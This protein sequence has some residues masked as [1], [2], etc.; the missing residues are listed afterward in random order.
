MLILLVCT[1]LIAACGRQASTDDSGIQVTLLPSPAGQAGEFVTIRLSDATGQPVTDASVGLEGN[2]NHAGMAPVFTDSRLDS[3]DGSS[4]GLYTIPFQ[5]D[6]LG[7]W[8]VTVLITN[9]DGATVRRDISVNVST[10]GI[11]VE[12]AA[13]NTLRVTHAMAQ[14]APLAGGNGAVYLTIVNDTASADRLIAAESSVAAS[15]GFHETVNANGIVRM[16]ARPVGFEIPAGGNVVMQPGEKHIMLEEL[17]GAL[18]VGQTIKLTLRFETASAVTLTVPVIAAG[19]ALP[20]AASVVLSPAEASAPSASTI[21]PT[22]ATGHDHAAADAEEHNATDAQPAAATATTASH[23]LSTVAI[24]LHLLSLAEFHSMDVAINKEQRLAPDFADTLTHCLAVLTAVEW[25]A[26]GAEIAPNLAIAL[27]DLRAALEQGDLAA[28]G[29]PAMDVHDLHHEL[30]HQM[31][32]WMGDQVVLASAAPDSFALAAITHLIHQFD[33][34]LVEAHI[35][36][37]SVEYRDEIAASS[38]NLLINTVVW[39]AEAQ[40]SIDVLHALLPEFE[41]ALDHQDFVEAKTLAPQVQTAM[42]SLW[43]TIDPWLAAQPVAQGVVDPARIAIAH[44]LLLTADLSVSNDVATP[45]A[46]QADPLTTLHHLRF[47][48]DAT[49]WPV[50]A[51]AD[52]ST[53]RTTLAELESAITRQDRT[54]ATQLMTAIE[55]QVPA[56]SAVLMPDHDHAHM[57]H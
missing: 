17:K 52:I 40:A 23:S 6:M 49:V 7:D 5:F 36:Q 55:E 43:E 1:G 13:S 39:P 51:Q 33:F 42:Q 37:E 10:E 11:S 29:T 44:H 16:E 14:P 27:L 34:Q 38:T 50:E 8:I 12:G 46:V 32:N 25:P 19:E 48:V 21:T 20:V 54:A 57:S 9:A 3:A 31:G 53:L 24:V 4:D 30:E 41:K 56:L 2:M 18:A 26:D 28:A 22:P 47:V 35:D 15:A 45:A